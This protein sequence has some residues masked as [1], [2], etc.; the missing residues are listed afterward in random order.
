MAA[1]SA[2]KNTLGNACSMSVRQSLVPGGGRHLIKFPKILTIP[3][4]ERN[5]RE[6][7]V[8]IQ[9]QKRVFDFLTEYGANSLFGYIFQ[10]S[11]IDIAKINLVLPWKHLKVH[12]WLT[13]RIFSRLSFNNSI[14]HQFK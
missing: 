3:K 2:R 8:K 12:K 1:T 5:L 14:L 11:S 13:L 9:I 6:T 4:D 7:A 10:P